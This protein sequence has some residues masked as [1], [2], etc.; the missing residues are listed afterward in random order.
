M[1]GPKQRRSV[2]TSPW[3]ESWPCPAESLL[4]G[5]GSLPCDPN[6]LRFDFFSVQ[7][8][9]LGGEFCTWRIYLREQRLLTEGKYFHMR[10]KVPS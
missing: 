7:K 8:N 3:L 6:T 2:L 1:F 10:C 5:F 9:C 4:L